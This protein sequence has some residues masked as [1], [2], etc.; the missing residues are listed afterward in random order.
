MLKAPTGCRFRS[1]P[2]A[3]ETHGFHSDIDPRELAPEEDSGQTQQI[4]W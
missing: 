3:D 4:Q 2:G 1:G